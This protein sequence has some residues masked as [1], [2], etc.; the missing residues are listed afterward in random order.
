MTDRTLG[1]Y[2]YTPL[3][4]FVGSDR[5][6]YVARDKYGNYSALETVNVSVALPGTSVTYVDMKGSEAYNAALSLTEAGIMSG[7]QVGNQYYFYPDIAVSR[8]EFLV[9]A[10]N[11]A[12]ITEVPDVAS[13]VFFDDAEIPASMKGY[14]AA[15]YEMKYISGTLSQ[16]KLCFLP[17]ESITRA[18]AAVMLSNIVGLCDVA[19]TPTFADGR[20]IPVW[21]TEAIYSLNAAGI[22][23]SDQGYIT[24]TA[25]VTRAQTAQL[26]S[27]VM[28]YVG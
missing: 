14:V 23:N 19:V 12:G 11:A 2:V 27:A 7:T 4:G 6:S 25:T 20:D 28:K 24:P 26:L 18:Q 1:T 13:T 3:E 10:M 21:A 8:V 5:F 22:M 9:M 15:A 16:G 17:N